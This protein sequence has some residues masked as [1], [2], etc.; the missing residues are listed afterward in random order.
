VATGKLRLSLALDEDGESSKPGCAWFWSTDDS[1]GEAKIPR[2]NA[3][4]YG[5]LKFTAKS[6]CNAETSHSIS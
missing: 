3:W 5:R 4:G 6:V 2:V 1:L